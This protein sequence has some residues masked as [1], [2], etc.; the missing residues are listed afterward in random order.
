MC[1][2]DRIIEQWLQA[3]ESDAAT[4]KMLGEKHI[5]VAPILS[6]KEVMEHP[7]MQ[8]RG[9]VRTVTDRGAGRF[10]MP[11]MPL[12]FSAFDNDLKLDAPYLGEHN[13]EVLTQLLGMDS[14]KIQA[15]TTQGVLINEP[16][17][18]SHP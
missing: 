9:T 17:P 3:Q 2:R 16:L 15:L 13:A 4:I 12:R 10:D 11:G 1:I 7:H 6:I 14:G 18:D 5:P 8:A